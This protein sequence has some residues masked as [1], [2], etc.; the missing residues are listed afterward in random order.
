[1]A[2]SAGTRLGPYE[3]L[4]PL[5]AGGMGEV[6]RARDGKLGREVA[7]KVLPE[8]FTKHPEKLA[9]FEREAKLLGALNHPGIA[10]LHGLEESGGEPFLVMELVEGET[11]AERIARGPLPVEE[12]LSVSQQIA[13]ALEAAHE[14]GVIHRDLKPANIKVDAEGQAKVLDFGLAK[15]WG[16]EA[17]GSSSSASL[18]QSPT[19][20]HSGTQAGVILGTASYMSPEQAKGKGVDK[21]TDVF[22]FG[23][24]LFEMLAGHKAFAGEDVSDVLASVIKLEPE[25]QAL[26][27]GLDPRIQSL[28]RRSLRKDRKKRLQAI[29][30]VRVEIEDILADPPGSPSHTHRAVAAPSRAPE[31]VAWAVALLLAVL[32]A[33]TLRRSEPPEPVVTEFAVTLP[34][35][36][37]LTQATS[38]Q[39]AFS[40]DAS[41][42]VYVANQQLYLREMDQLDAVPIRGTDVDP[43]G[44]F[45]SP[46]GQWVGFIEREV[47]KRVSLDGGAPLTVCAVE[48]VRGASWGADDRIVFADPRGILRV[49]ASGGTPEVV[50]PLEPNERVNEAQVLPGGQAILFS[51]GTLSSPR[52]GQI[53]TQS[54]ETGERKVHVASGADPRYV[55]TGHMVYALEETLVAAPF[56][57]ERLEVTG[58]PVPVLENVR[59]DYG[60]GSRAQAT[61]SASGSLAY[62]PGGARV[63]R[64]LAWV[65]R[66]GGVTP[67]SERSG[68]YYQPRLSSDGS[69]VAVVIEG[70][71]WIHDIERDARTRLTVEGRNIWPV[72]SPDDQWIAFNSERG[73]GRDLYRKRADSSGP[74]EIL[75][76]RPGTQLPRSWSPDGKDLL[77]IAVEGT[78]GKLDIWA[79]PIEGDREPWKVLESPFVD[80][81][82]AVSPNGR[83]MAYQSD[84]SGRDEVY[85]QAFT[86]GGR[87]WPISTGGGTTPRWSPSG[88]ELFYRNDQ[89]LMAVEVETEPDFQVQTPRVLFEAS[90]RLGHYDVAPDGQRFLFVVPVEGLAPDQINVVLNWAEELKR[91]VPTE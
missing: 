80:N 69:R 50:I 47:L 23:V 10:T 36:E 16:E 15:A 37:R 17:D 4:A 5:G 74:A 41:R 84:E 6:Y 2:L 52:H 51:L 39:L 7:I 26:P 56:D 61:I 73:G 33:G 46:D 21:R 30:D 12:A 75:L 45:F 14:K 71:I 11:L 9:R 60:A 85:V 29:G 27:P 76:E 79:L 13:E 28:L 77:Y 18:S 44:P 1:M 57:L 54:L 70:D 68:Q 53:A 58:D 32:A 88:R 82:P 65:D 66:G 8:E 42:L 59:R 72:W 90:F 40:P 3:I 48:G 87:R 67:F 20:A 19:L 49:S 83:W 35:G 55:P 31:R 78:G 91:L 38:R 81:H 24:V 62:V 89:E 25:W 43:S 63:N 86:D 64:T 22:S 34:A